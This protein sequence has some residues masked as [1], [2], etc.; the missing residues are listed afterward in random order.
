M[1][2][3]SSHLW[4]IQNKFTQTIGT[5]LFQIVQKREKKKKNCILIYD[6]F[7]GVKKYLFSRK[8]IFFFFKKR[9]KPDLFCL[10]LFFSHD[11]YSTNTT[12][13]KSVLGT[14][15]WGGRIVGADES[16][17]LWW[18]PLN[19]I[20]KLTTETYSSIVMSEL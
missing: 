18:H 11:K 13:E 16:T 8:N 19:N 14:R 1:C 20:F 6:T 4:S 5:L 3:I 10:F 9:A 15:T 7:C 2:Q 17:E 12:N